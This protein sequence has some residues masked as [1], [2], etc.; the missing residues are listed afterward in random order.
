MSKKLKIAV[1][2]LRFGGEFAEIYRDHPDVEEVILCERDGTL[3]NQYG[4][5]FG[6]NRRYENYEELLQSDVDAIHIVSGIPSHCEL[7]VRALQAGKHCAC[8]VPMAVSLEEIR[9]IIDAQRQSQTN[10]MMME[11]T[12]YGFQTFFVKQMIEE[13]RI[14]DIQYM[15]GIHFQ[16][17]EGWPDYWMG[18]PPM[19]YATHAVAPLLY[20]SGA[21]PKSV[22]CLGSGRMREE[23]QT[24]YQ[25]PFPVETAR[26]T[27][28]DHPFVAD[29][30]RSLFETAHDYVEGF[31]IM[32]DQG[33]FEMNVE[34]ESPV[35]SEFVEE[36]NWTNMGTRG[37]KIRTQR[38]DCPNRMELLPEAIRKYTTQCTILDPENPHHSIQQGGGHHGSHPHMVHEFVRSI[39][40]NRKPA[41]DALQAA[42]Y[43]AIGICAHQS[44]MQNGAQISIPKFD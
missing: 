17:M 5:M 4:D 39:V 28:H 19:H 3:L 9:Q 6:Y 25:N 1:V 22:S 14:G 21:R 13:G 8:T 33:C 26:V 38:V 44:A 32:G 34:C 24:Q 30:T 10:Y 42:Y 43:T 29:V 35:F 36:R 15:R 12:V 31:T 7:T 2:G 37:R 23:L 20:L 11:T 40:E 27:F 18:L 16:D 41:I